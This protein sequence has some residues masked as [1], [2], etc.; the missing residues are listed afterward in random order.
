M[1]RQE[2][3]THLFIQDLHDGTLLEPIEG[4]ANALTW[5]TWRTGAGAVVRR[6]VPA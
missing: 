4:R 1:A 3:K 6:T 2:S 5:R